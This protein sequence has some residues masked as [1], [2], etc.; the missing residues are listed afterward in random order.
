MNNNSGKVTHDL[1]N[2]LKGKN[3]RVKKLVCWSAITLRL[4]KQNYSVGPDYLF[5]EKIFSWISHVKIAS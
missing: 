5:T 4:N 1:T 3:I 2:Q